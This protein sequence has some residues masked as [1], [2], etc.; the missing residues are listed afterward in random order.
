MRGELVFD[1]VYARYASADSDA[2]AGVSLRVA[3]GESVALVGPSGSGKTT[4]VNLIPRFYEPTE[5]DILLDGHRIDALT[6]ANLRSHIALV[7]QDITLFDDT[8]AANIAYGAMSSAPRAAIEQAAKAAHALEFIQA[9]PQGFDTIV[10][11]NGI[12]LSGGQRQRLAIARA[13]LKNAPILILDEATSALD[14]ES[15]R[16]VQAAMETLMQGRTTIVI[17]HRLSTIE[18]VDRIVVL[19][20]GRVVEHGTHAELLARNGLYAKLHRIQF[21]TVTL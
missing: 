14:S 15:E 13:I 7:S 1:H 10:G 20:A 6:L 5:G 4:L 12:R 9:L 19:D 18:R 2:L 3:P 11:D 17:A 21:A 16:H 8:V